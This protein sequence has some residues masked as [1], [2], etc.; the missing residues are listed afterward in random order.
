MSRVFL[1]QPLEGSATF[2]RVY[3]T[4]GVTQGF[5]THDR[6]LRFGGVLHRAAPGMLPS[7]IRRTADLSADSA[8]AKGALTHDSISEEDLGLGRFDGAQVEVGVVDWE[9]LEHA[10]LYR[11]RIGAVSQE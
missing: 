10:V 11:G 2:W 9:T 6:D 4:D 3:R 8:E 7:A 1:S 5:T